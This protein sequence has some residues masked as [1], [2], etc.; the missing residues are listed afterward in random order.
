MLVADEMEAYREKFMSEVRLRAEADQNYLQGAFTEYCATLLQ[1]ADEIEGFEPAFYRGR[2]L[3]NRALALDGYSID[4]VDA[5]VSILVADF[6]QGDSPR[7]VT[8][9]LAEQLFTRAESFLDEALRGRLHDQLDESHPANDVAYHVRSRYEEISKFRIYLVSNGVLSTRVKEVATTV[10]EGIPVEHH[11]WDL[12]RFLRVAQSATGRDELEVDFTRHMPTGIPCLQAAAGSGQY[13]AYLCVVP[14]STL[15]QI[16]EAHGSRLLEGNV[17][18]FLSIRGKVN[19]GIRA[20]L[21]KEPDMFFAYNNGISATATDLKVIETSSGL[22]LLQA[23]DF[24]IVNGGQTTASLA[25]AVKKDRSTLDNVFVQMKL[26][27]ISPDQAGEIIPQISRYA[28]SQNKINDADFFA[29]HEFHRRMEQISRRLLAPAKGGAQF[30]THWFYERARGQYENEAARLTPA[31]KK[32]FELSFPKKQLITKTDLAKYEFSWRMLPHKVSYGAQKNFMFF[33]EEISKE[34]E[35]SSDHFNEEFYREIVAKAILFEETA[36]IVTSQTWYQGGYRA[37]TVTHTVARLAKLVRDCARNGEFD[38][39]II[40]QQQSLPEPLQLQIAQIAKEVFGVLT[41]PDSGIQNVTEWS[42][43]EACWTRV[44]ATKPEIVP[45]FLAMITDRKEVAQRK[46]DAVQLQ[47]VDSGISA[48]Q[49][50]VEQ[51]ATFWKHLLDWG[52]KHRILGPDEIAGL[53]LAAR[54]PDKIPNEIHCKKI[55]QALER[56]RGE[57]FE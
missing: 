16:Y 26:S 2:G 33:A 18:S 31:E 27:V 8:Q 4:D 48:Q 50:V 24:Q 14:G 30:E 47:R 36:K 13:Q 44:A 9:S 22:R 56:A 5:S 19:K 39:R 10:L 46:R 55:L 29:N 21:L 6:E 11:I 53:K 43:K 1:E 38:F 17:R 51:P 45:S 25:N 57:G 40:W 12:S 7:S 20:T 28:N 34:W 41:T 32:K 52:Q 49:Q 54:L 37:Q 23:K 3:R 42:K 15:A 35:R